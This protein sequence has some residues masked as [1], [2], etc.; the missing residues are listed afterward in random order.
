MPS[1]DVP[2]CDGGRF[3]DRRE[4]QPR[5]AAVRHAVLTCFW[6]VLFA[7]AT[8]Q[9]SL[10]V[11]G[12]S[13]AAAESDGW[14][15]RPLAQVLNYHGMTMG[16][17]YYLQATSHGAGLVG[18]PET[19]NLSLAGTAAVIPT[20][21]AMET[22]PK[23][24]FFIRLGGDG[25]AGPFF[26]LGPGISGFAAEPHLLGEV[27]FTAN[28]EFVLSSLVAQLLEDW[29]G[30]SIGLPGE[31]TLS[32]L[33]QAVGAGVQL[34]YFS[35]YT[36]ERGAHGFG[37]GIGATGFFTQSDLGAP[38]ALLGHACL[39]ASWPFVELNIY[40]R[41]PIWTSE[42]RLYRELGQGSLGISFGLRDPL[43][44]LFE[45]LGT[46]SR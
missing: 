27:Y 34:R 35:E 39:S 20:P 30:V 36:V 29:F 9:V 5:P 23:L 13:Q 6:V 40:Y 14:M 25:A 32:P 16:E 24:H 19:P 11:V 10:Q 26:E 4:M 46:G 43:S 42:Q 1:R 7:V 31:L 41:V 37:I 22:E 45:L 33:G 3:S 21:Q 15:D 28:G 17:Y 2:L 8:C 12:A 38:L 18:A 44:P